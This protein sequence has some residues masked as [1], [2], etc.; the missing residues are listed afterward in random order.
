[1][2]RS[3]AAFG[4]ATPLPDNFHAASSAP[5]LDGAVA[6]V[7][8][9][10]P[11]E[12]LA[13]LVSLDDYEA[14]A[15]ARLEPTVWEFIASGAADERTLRWNREAF[16][17]LRLAPRA[18]VDVSRI[19]TRTTILGHELAAPLLI[20]PTA[21][22]RLVHPEAELATARAAREA[23]VGMVLSSFTTVPV[24]EVARVGPRP[25]WFQLYVQDRG[26][27]KE[28]VQRVSAVGCS[29]LCV[30]VDTPGL[31][32]RNR[33]ARAGFTFPVGLPHLQ[34][35]RPF[36]LYPVTWKDLEWLRGVS[37]VPVIPK[38]I[39]DPQDADQAVTAGVAAIYVSNHGARNLDTVP[40][41][42]DVLP[43]IVD[44]VAGRVPILFDGGVRRGTDILKALAYGA[45]AA[46]VG[47]PIL[48]GLAVDGAAG[49]A[50]VV[51]ILRHE[52]ESSMALTGRPSL[53][54]IDRTVLWS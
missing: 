3:A 21:C 49:V 32:V 19:D 36:G 45:G 54:S 52:L 29:A 1:M 9:R 5:L 38:G 20:A 51:A 22:H 15:H 46:L 37:P 48:Y 2:P 12:H 18:F 13:P 47:R 41:T 14:A 6:D 11:G 24:E 25:L 44:R 43:R 30:T 40:A 26:F 39:L 7:P 8:T 53:A 17:Q 10:A 27:T 16:E 50:N 23:G 31:G 28:L 34:P 42:I 35:G 4:A 33:Q